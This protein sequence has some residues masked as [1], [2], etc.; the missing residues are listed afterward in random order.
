M[1]KVKYLNDVVSPFE[2]E[3]LI[4]DLESI[5]FEDYTSVKMVKKHSIIERLNMQAVKNALTGSDDYILEYFVTYDKIVD[6]IKELL[7]ARHWKT[8]VFPLIK[9]QICEI[10]GV[11]A[12]V[13]LYHEA[14]IINLLENFFFHLTA[15]QAA[16]DYLIEVVEY[17]YQRIS[18]LLLDVES[19]KFKKIHEPQLKSKEDILKVNETEDMVFKLNEM[20][21]PIALSCISIVRYVSDHLSQLPFPIRHHLI[22]VKDVLLILIPIL[23]AKPWIKKDSNGK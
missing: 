18:K 19:G 7:I 13:C 6:I 9:D 14:V 23:E 20:E 2:A 8:H 17:C 5:S 22:N 16:G 10:S 1:N 15:C 4:K 11:K 3:H 21:L 12:Y